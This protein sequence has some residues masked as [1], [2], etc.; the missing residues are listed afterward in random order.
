MTVAMPSSSLVKPHTHTLPLRV[1][2]RGSPLALIQTRGFLEVLTHFCPV[3]R[4]LKVAART[5]EL[6]D[7]DLIELGQTF[8]LFRKSLVTWA[9]LPLLF[10][11]ASSAQLPTPSRPVVMSRIRVTA[12]E[13]GVNSITTRTIGG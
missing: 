10:A 6:E 3:L 12:W 5:A 9:T 4:N 1:G 11:I 2:T 7:G 8:F 13:R